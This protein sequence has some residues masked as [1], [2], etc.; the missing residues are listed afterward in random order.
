MGN[1][2]ETAEEMSVVDISDT[3]GEVLVVAG[4]IYCE[5]GREGLG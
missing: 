2:Y 5:E 1:N 4:P 3:A